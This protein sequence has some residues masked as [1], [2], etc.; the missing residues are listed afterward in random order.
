MQHL[1]KEGERFQMTFSSE[2]QK[3]AL[4]SFK[5]SRYTAQILLRAAA[6]LNSK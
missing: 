5:L 6:P 1:F 2:D 3:N 4:L